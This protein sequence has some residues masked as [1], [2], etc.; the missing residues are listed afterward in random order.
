VR[1]PAPDPGADDSGAGELPG[2]NSKRRMPWAY[3]ALLIVGSLLLV[4]AGGTIALIYGLSGRY[5]TKVKQEDILPPDVTS[6]HKTYAGPLNFLVLGTDSRDNEQTE[7]ADSTGSN[8]DTILLVHIDKGLDSAFI[9]SI[10]RD[11]YVNIPPGG[12]WKGGENK[13]NAAFDH[14]GAPLAAQTVFN[15]THIPLDGA[16]II[17]FAGVENMVN[18]VGGIRVCPPYDVGNWFPDFKQYGPDKVRSD[19]GVVYPGWLKGHCY[20]MNGTEAMVFARQRHIVAG[21]D[22]GR[23]RNQ[24]LVMQ[25]LAEK[26][27]SAGMLTDLRKLDSLLL[28]AA[29]S[30]T[31]DRGMSLRDLA[32]ALKGISPSRIQFATVPHLGTFTTWAG[33]SVK[34]NFPKCQ[35]LFQAILDDRTDAWLAAHPQ[36][37]EASYDAN[38]TA[39]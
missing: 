11:S 19:A 15:L 22:F 1:D 36:P 39:N 37:T 16:V 5:E 25:A 27:T 32:F 35:E 29:E 2:T 17:N 28:A 3:T 12:D 20:Q 8:S 18:A 21:G 31:I 9:V 13:I 7:S 34:L 23:I 4:A 24:Q 6:T 14:G 30:L 26:A 10:P 33:S 38:S